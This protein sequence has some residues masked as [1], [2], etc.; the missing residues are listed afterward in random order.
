MIITVLVIFVLPA[1]QRVLRRGGVRHRRRAARPRSREGGAGRS[2]ARRVQASC[3]DPQTT[4]P[5][6]RDGAARDHA[7]SLGLGMYGEHALAEAGALGRMAHAGPACSPRT[8]SP[9]SSRS[10]SGRI[11]TSWSVRWCPNRSRCSE[12]SDPLWITPAMLWIQTL[13]YPLVVVSERV[14]NAVLRRFGID[15]QA[16]IARTVLHA[17]GTAAD[18]RGMRGAGRS[19]RRN[20]ARSCRSSSSSAT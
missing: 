8:A 7:R 6:H 1:R 3:E 20:R 4:R 2:L 19:S 5:G 15:R 12:P 18:R 14:G 16:V 9:A 11:S 17:R 13:F 10:R